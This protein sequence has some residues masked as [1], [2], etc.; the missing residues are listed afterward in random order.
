MK[1]LLCPACCA[2]ALLLYPLWLNEFLVSISV[3]TA[4]YVVLLSGLSLFLGYGGQFSFAQAVFYGIGAYTSG[5]L[6]T[7]FHIPPIMGFIA[8]GGRSRPCNRA[9]M[10]PSSSESMHSG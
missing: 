5:L 1:R 4:I 2:I 8:S 6:V 10:P 9:R 3:V 7:R